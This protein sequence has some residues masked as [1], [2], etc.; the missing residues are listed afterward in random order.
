MSDAA[1]V[2]TY[3]EA[4]PVC[5]HGDRLAFTTSCRVIGN[6]IALVELW[7]KEQAGDS[8]DGASI[9]RWA[10]SI[11]GHPLEQQ[12]RWASY[13]HDRLCEQSRTW[14]Q[15]RLADAVLLVLLHEAGVTY[16]RRTAMW[17]A[18]RAYAWIVWRE[19]RGAP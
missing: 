6:D 4:M 17:L 10:W 18:V 2:I 13:W 7:H 12:F 16:W 1:A 9:P 8:W 19:S 11:I 3:A 5:L 15:R 14:A